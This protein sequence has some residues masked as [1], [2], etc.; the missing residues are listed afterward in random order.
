MQLKL[1]EC[2]ALGL[3]VCSTGSLKLWIQSNFSRVA[4]RI[5]NTTDH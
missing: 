4:N 3:A 5:V 1:M 2:T